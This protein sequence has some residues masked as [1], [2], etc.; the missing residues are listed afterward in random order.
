[1]T[2]SYA[3]ELLAATQR[4]HASPSALQDLLSQRQPLHTISR[5]LFGETLASSMTP[6]I[7]TETA[8]LTSSPVESNNPLEAS[9]PD[10]PKY[11]QTIGSWWGD[12]HFITFDN[13]K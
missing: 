2:R 9:V 1:M 5:L 13:L 12:P 8:P 3:Q 7:P 4:S 11:T 10:V 6:S